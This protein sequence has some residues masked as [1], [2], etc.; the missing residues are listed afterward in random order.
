ME[1]PRVSITGATRIAGVIGW[2]IQH[3]LSPAMQ[4]AAFSHY[5]LD[6]AYVP[7]GVPPSGLGI[8][9]KSLQQLD[10]VGVNVTIPYKEKVI[11]YLDACA[12][13]AKQIGAVNTIVFHKLRIIG[14][15]TDGLGF[16]QSIQGVARI[17]GAQAVVLG[18]G[19][20]GRAIAVSLALA[21]AGQ[22]T[23]VDVDSQRLGRLIRDIRKLGY[24]YVRGTRPSTAELKAQLGKSQLLVNATPLGLK[25][26]DPL[27][28]PPAWMPSAVCV[29]DVVYG[30]RM[31]PLLRLA[32][33][34]KN[35]I[36][37]GWKMLLYQGAEAFR[38]WT[39]KNPPVNLMQQALVK[40]GG[41]IG[42]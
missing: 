20:A 8:L 3:T 36:V 40:A 28:L 38:L 15:N 34:K 2:P 21:G 27:P 26:K 19:G 16:L 30:K 17:K 10:A 18:A 12:P 23:L 31:T 39:G 42:I 7:L 41:L 25:S 14:H 13:S 11:P 33:A 4:N 5:G 32:K 24:P 29:L 9:V 22:L 1:K 37:P 35:R 6:V